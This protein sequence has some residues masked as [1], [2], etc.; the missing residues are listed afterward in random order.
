VIILNPDCAA[1]KC[2]ACSGDG[3]DDEAEEL[4]SC[5]H[6][7]HARLRG[8]PLADSILGPIGRKGISNVVADL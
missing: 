5:P 4:A 6:L 8:H 3:Y 1:G 2:A 7:C